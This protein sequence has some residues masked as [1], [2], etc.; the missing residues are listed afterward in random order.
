[1]RIENIGNTTLYLGDCR[2]IIPTLTG[3]NAVCT[4]P[5]Y[6]IEELVGGYG[7]SGELIANDKNLDVCEEGLALA[8]TAAPDALFAVFYSSP[9][10]GKSQRKGRREHKC[11][12]SRLPPILKDDSIEDK[13]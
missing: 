4:D 12:E 7:R 2:E 9:S 5:P 1:M 11:R 6:G 3:I 10:Q 8:A 13:Q